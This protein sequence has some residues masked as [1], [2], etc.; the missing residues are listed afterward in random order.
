MVFVLPFLAFIFGA[1][2]FASPCCLP[3][4]PGYVSFISGLPMSDLDR[5]A[6]RKVA[7]R[8]SLFFVAGFTLVF[9]GQLAAGYQQPRQLLSTIPLSR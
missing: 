7:L 4:S 2:S 8:V 1:I 3:L 9:S 5:G 6:S